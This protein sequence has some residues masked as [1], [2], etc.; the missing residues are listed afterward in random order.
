MD[1]SFIYNII[2]TELKNNNNTDFKG[3]H[4]IEKENVKDYITMPY[5]NQFFNPIAD[6]IEE[7]W[8]VFDEDIKSQDKGYLIFFSESDNGFGIGTKTNLKNIKNAGTFL[9]IYGSFIDAINSL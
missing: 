6:N 3:W 7:H 5:K 8:V 4:G 1:S 2:L 9:G